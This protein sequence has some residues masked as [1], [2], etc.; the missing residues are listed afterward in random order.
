VA[1]FL[2]ASTVRF[3][4]PPDPLSTV[5]F[6]QSYTPGLQKDAVSIGTK[7]TPPPFLKICIVTLKKKNLLYGY[8]PKS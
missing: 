5:S 4:S 6:V 3:F 8:A 2:G 7:T 1:F